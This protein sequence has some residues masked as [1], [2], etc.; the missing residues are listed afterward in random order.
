MLDTTCFNREVRIADSRANL[1]LG[2]SKLEF[3]SV[4]G[5]TPLESYQVLTMERTLGMSDL[6]TPVQTSYT[7]STVPSKNDKKQ[8]N[9]TNNVKVEDSIVQKSTDKVLANKLEDAGGMG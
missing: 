2:G 8:E 7:M 1:S 3:L 4:S 6:F 9:T 5:Y